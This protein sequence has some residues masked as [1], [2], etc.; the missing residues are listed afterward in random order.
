MKF[1]FNFYAVY[2]TDVGG[3]VINGV[4]LRGVEKRVEETDEHE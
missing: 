4:M 2:F 3:F 1:L